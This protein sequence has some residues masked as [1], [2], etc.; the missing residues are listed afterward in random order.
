MSNA[1]FTIARPDNDAFRGY[2]PG[3]KERAGTE[4]EPG[5]VINLRKEG[6]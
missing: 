6:K 4:P 5:T 1:Y 2:L 3:S